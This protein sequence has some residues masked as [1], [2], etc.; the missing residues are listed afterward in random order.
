MAFV[1]PVAAQP[2][3]LTDDFSDGDFSG[4]PAWIGD[5]A[6]FAVEGGWLRSRGPESSSTLVLSTELP[7][8]VLEWRILLRLDFDPSSSN[9]IRIYLSADRSD[10]QDDAQGYFLQIGESGA[11][12][13]DSIDFYRSDGATEQRLLHSA[14]PCIRSAT[15]NDIGLRVL[16]SA[17]GVWS[18]WADCTGGD[19]YAL[20]AEVLD[21]TYPVQDWFGLYLRYTTGSRFD[22]Y[23]ADNVYAGPI[24]VDTVPP[25]LLQH[26]LLSATELRLS[27][28][29]SMDSASVREPLHYV[30][31]NGLDFPLVVFPDSVDPQG[32]VLQFEEPFPSGAWTS[33][34]LA[35]PTDRTG[36]TLSDTLIA[37]RYYAVQP[38][39]LIIT[40]FMADASPP[41]WLLPEAEYVEILNR[42]EERLNLSGYRLRDGS[43]STGAFF[44]DYTLEP[45][46]YLL[47]CNPSDTAVFTGF[48]RVLGL[49]DFPLLNN[50]ADRLEILL[51][52]GRSL[53]KI[54]YVMDWYGDAGK[55]GGGWSIEILDIQRPW[56]GSCNWSAS[57]A[58]AQGTPG[59]TNSIRNPPAA[60]APPSLL[61]VVPW[62]PFLLRVQ[63]DQPMDSVSLSLPRHFSI[64]PSDVVLSGVVPEGPD[65]HSA[66]L[67]LDVPLLAGQ[68]YSLRAVGQLGCSGL[69]PDSS[70]TI[71]FGLPESPVRGDVVI[72][73]ILFDPYS[74]GE[75]FVEV[76][77]G[78]SKWINLAGCWIVEEDP[79][80]PGKMKEEAL[81]APE[82]LLL[83]PESHL[84]FAETA[85]LTLHNYPGTPASKL[86]AIPDMPSWPDTEERG[87]VRLECRNAGDTLVLDRVPFSTDWHYPLL[88]DPEGVSLERI[89]F[90]AKSDDSNNWHSA[91]RGQGYATPG[92]RNS[93]AMDGVP[94]LAGSLWIDPP[95]F[96]PDQDGYNDVLQI[97]YRFDRPG[98]TAT[99][100]V[101]DIRGFPIRNL[102][103][104][105]T[106]EPSGFITWDGLNE[107]SE[108]ASPGIYLFRMDAFDPEGRVRHF[109]ESGVLAVRL[110]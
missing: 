70:D 100:Q 102:L 69:L 50:D 32:W 106:L 22:K 24:M 55:E 93:V 71:L 108:R 103:N 1:Q 101:Y 12:L 85:E 99:L 79:D 35:G 107:R 48:G 7:D 105:V 36:N 77:N 15:R 84:A 53:H 38:F 42:S 2:G 78:T 96:S 49:Y 94:D 56:L 11:T 110:K 13:S 65:F 17:V 8:S 104:T 26:Q 64:T 68:E 51:P 47:L 6:N 86:R 3:V 23:Y 61:Q 67:H 31:S 14:F 58:A 63:F 16:R 59:I 97:H 75:D 52:D 60:A 46:Q 20:G 9:Y 66:T 27:F 82:G 72:N 25:L 89:G 5:T 73:E 109:R 98:F 95:V 39:D 10:L 83:P 74:G 81:L 33:V 30:A 80:V 88:D 45:G 28:S 37:V 62:S 92:R 87:V 76:Y 19:E 40:E 54:N 43:S 90:N 29:E 34:Q 41:G 44:P 91:A 18:I 4:D 57:G 21:A